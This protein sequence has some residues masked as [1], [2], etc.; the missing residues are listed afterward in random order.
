MANF[1]LNRAEILYRC[2]IP[3]FDRARD[4]LTILNQANV[5]QSNIKVKEE[6]KNEKKNIIVVISECALQQQG[7][8][9]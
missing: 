8:P 9:A 3:P 4:V 6:D 1:H 5:N 7:I 2:S